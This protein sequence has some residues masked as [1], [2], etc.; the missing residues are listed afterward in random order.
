M[1]L[2][3]ATLIF[4]LALVAPSELFASDLPERMSWRGPLPLGDTTPLPANSGAGGAAFG[5][6]VHL[7]TLVRH[8][9]LA[10]VRL[11]AAG[12]VLDPLPVIIAGPG[13]LIQEADVAWDGRRFLVV[14]RNYFF[15]LRGRFVRP[16]GTFEGGAFPISEA[17]PTPSIHS[18]DEALVLLFGRWSAEYGGVR[19]T[20]MLT[21]REQSPRRRG[22]V[23]GSG[24]G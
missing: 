22:V 23:R 11:D 10:L 16:D 3:R 1:T 15:E 12:N 21:T 7:V 5:G 9:N 19:R 8:T 17:Y 20:Y 18:D 4:L 24:G 14:W 6:G 13:T 2:M